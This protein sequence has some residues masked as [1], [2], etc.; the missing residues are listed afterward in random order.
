MAAN[1]S[2]KYGLS[3]FFANYFSNFGR[4]LLANLLFCVPL[5]ILGGGVVL[6]TNR[7]G[8]LSMF[9]VFLLIPLMS[10]FFGGL[11]NVCRKLTADQGFH[12]L[13]DFFRGVRDN[14]LF[15]LVNSMM[16]YA[17]TVG[18]YIMVPLSRSAD[19]SGLTMYLITMIITAAV[20]VLAEFSAVVMAVSVELKFADIFKNSF[21]LLLKGFANHLRTLLS[22]LFLGFVVYSIAALINEMTIVLIVTGVLVLT[23]L[24]VMTVY[25]ITYN[26]YQTI[27]KHIIQ[28]YS[29]E[30]QQAEQQRRLQEQEDALT[31]ADLEPLAKGDPEEYVYLNGKTVKRKVIL[32]MISVR[33]EKE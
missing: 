26:A 24:P 32:Q 12:P 15:F 16:L 13:K 33:R 4:L 7:L 31:I 19:S 2:R 28:P 17:L 3:D 23:V 27:E 29:K 22:L 25:I 6:L 11:F 10:P 21:I 20:F 1:A 14:W 9:V 8:S 30:V 18:F 5:A